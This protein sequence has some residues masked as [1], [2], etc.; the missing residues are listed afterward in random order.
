MLNGP[1]LGDFHLLSA[2]PLASGTHVSRRSCDRPSRQTFAWS[3]Y[4]LKQT[5]RRFPNSKL[6]L[7]DLIQPSRF[8]FT[9]IKRP[10]KDNRIILQHSELT[11]KGPYFIPPLFTTLSSFPCHS[12]RKDEREASQ[13]IAKWYLFSQRRVSHL[14]IVLPFVF[15]LHHTSPSLSLSL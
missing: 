2:W 1:A 8:K 3:A 5:L 4:I 12:Y 15:L 14:L 7:H 13:L 9:E 11:S 6:L 10:F